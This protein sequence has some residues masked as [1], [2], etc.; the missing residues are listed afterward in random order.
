MAERM[1]GGGGARSLAAA[2][3]SSAWV[4]GGRSLVQLEADRV[5]RLGQHE[6]AAR[7]AG[8]R[9]RVNRH[10]RH[11]CPEGPLSGAP[12]TPLRLAQNCPPFGRLFRQS[13]SLTGRPVRPIRVAAVAFG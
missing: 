2:T 9:A 11:S 10:Q 6:A 8:V 1:S 12:A 4:Y 7:V 13:S 5:S 3:S